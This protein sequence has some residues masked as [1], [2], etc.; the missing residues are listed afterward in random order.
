MRRV[1]HSPLLKWLVSHRAHIRRLVY[2]SVKLVGLGLRD[3][4][5]RWR[6]LCWLTEH[7]HLEDFDWDGGLWAR[8]ILLMESL[9]ARAARENWVWIIMHKGVYS[10]S[11]L[12]PDQ[13]FRTLFLYFELWWFF[14]WKPQRLSFM[15][16]HSATCL[17]FRQHPLHIIFLEVCIVTGI[18]H[19]LI[20][21]FVEV[22]ALWGWV[23]V[24]DENLVPSCCC[25]HAFA[26][27]GVGTEV[28]LWCFATAAAA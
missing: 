3:V 19:F 18:K 21:Y 11:F 24:V 13:H 25:K 15:L 2:H 17:S 26:C 10:D 6:C 4:V 20:I 28:F 16:D 27:L 9:H 22:Y 12:T 1:R 5:S 8:R 7:V 23:F 14:P